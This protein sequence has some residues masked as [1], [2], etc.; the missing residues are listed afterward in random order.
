MGTTTC[1]GG[2]S[3]E[4]KTSEQRLTEDE[5]RVASRPRPPV[6]G[7]GRGGGGTEAEV[8]PPAVP[9]RRETRLHLLAAEV[10]SYEAV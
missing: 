6:R 9:Q 4:G 5:L 7:R 3:T 10:D 1:M 2:W 8:G